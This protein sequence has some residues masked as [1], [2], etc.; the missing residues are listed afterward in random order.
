MSDY[1]IPSEEFSFGDMEIPEYM[2]EGINAY[3]ENHRPCGDFLR[4]IIENNLV[5]A[6]SHADWN[7]IRLLPAY[8]NLLYNDFPPGSWGSREAYINWVKNN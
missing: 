2:R 3:V 1:K 4:S 5:S 6:C 8:A 7:N